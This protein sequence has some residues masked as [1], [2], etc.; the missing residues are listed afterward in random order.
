[1]LIPNKKSHLI[2]V[3]YKHPSTKHYEFNND[4]MNTLL[5]KLTLENKPSIITGDFNLNL[6][7]YMQNTGVNQ[8]LENILSNNFIPQITFPIKITEKTAT[9]IDNIFTSS[10]K[11]NSNCV[12]GNITTYISDHLP[13]FLIIE[14][15]KQPSFKQNPPISFR[16]CK[17]F[18][19]EAFKTELCELD[20]SFVTENNN[21]NLSFETFLHFINRIS[22]KHAPIKTVKKREI[23]SKPWIT[24][25]I[26]ISMKEKDKLYKQMIKAKNKQQKLIKLE[27]YKECRNKIIEL[28]R[29]SKQTYYQHHFDQNKKSSEAIWQSIYEIIS[30]TKNKK[31]GNVSDI[32]ADDNAITDPIEIAENFN[33]FFTSIGTNL[34]K[35]TPP[36][37]KTFTDYLKKPNSENFI[38][39]PTTPE[40]ISDLIHNLKSSK[41]VG[42]YIIPTKIMKISK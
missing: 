10:Y 1:M 22:D 9:L 32:S 18:N 19:E 40:E 6:I 27:S 14:N 16:D 37:R 24:R 41:S 28:I 30:S 7:K 35:K 26:K 12:S 29:Q 42:P 23:I 8:F 2:G 34:K 17:N 36:T 39:A 25:G 5:K 4:F 15:L 3:V 33:N 31:G 20:W 13:Q 11:Y 38:I 21:I